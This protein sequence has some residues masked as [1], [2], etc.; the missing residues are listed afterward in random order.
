VDNLGL[1][2]ETVRALKARGIASL[3]PIQRQVLQPA[4]EG[5]D[6]I[7]RAKTG[8]GK[9]LAF[10]LPVVESLLAE[11]KARGSRKAAGRPPRCAA[12]AAAAEECGICGVLQ[13]SVA[14]AQEGAVYRQQPWG[15]C[16][17][18]IDIF[19]ASQLVTTVVG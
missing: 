12:A 15:Y 14:R 1:S 13:S 5:T 16:C 4:M 10:A 3:F 8:S 9:T 18:T 7:G 2:D 6:L 19:G 11:D 17:K